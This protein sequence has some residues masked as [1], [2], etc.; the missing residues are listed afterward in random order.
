MKILKIH[1]TKVNYVFEIYV[2]I[3]KFYTHRGLFQE[4]NLPGNAASHI[5]FK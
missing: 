4:E 1:F 5:T 2:K 3:K